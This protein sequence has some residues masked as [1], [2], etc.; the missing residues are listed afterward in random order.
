MLLNFIK[1]QLVI[2]KKYNKLM[3]RFNVYKKYNLYFN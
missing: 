3:N 2:M 1:Y